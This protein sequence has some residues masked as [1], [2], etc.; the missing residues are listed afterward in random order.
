M[1]IIPLR[2]ARAGFE[3]T[4]SAPKTLVLPL[5]DRAILKR[6][7]KVKFDFVFTKKKSALGQKNS[8]PYYLCTLFICYS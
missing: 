2:V 1:L 4:Y 5:D 8:A 3:P 7:A 6:T